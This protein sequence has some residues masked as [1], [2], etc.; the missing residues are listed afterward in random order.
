MHQFYFKET[1]AAPTPASTDT[2]PSIEKYRFARLSLSRFPQIIAGY[3]KK[4]Q[5]SSKHPGDPQH[6]KDIKDTCTDCLLMNINP[7][8][9]NF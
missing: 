9:A 6:D 3:L 7:A 8:Q 5:A 1:S 4:L 2:A